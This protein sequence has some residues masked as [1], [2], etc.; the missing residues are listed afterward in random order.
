MPLGT[1]VDLGPGHVQLD[2]DPSLLQ[3]GHSSPPIFGSDLLW[4]NSWMDQGITLQGGIR[5]GPGDTVHS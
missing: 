1:E 5:H 3:K 4:P 2:G